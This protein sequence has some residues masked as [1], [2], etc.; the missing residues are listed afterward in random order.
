M[1][2]TQMDQ[3]HA[4]WRTGQ[5]VQI[6]PND[7]SQFARYA[8]RIDQKYD[9]LHY[10]NNPTSLLFLTEDQNAAKDALVSAVAGANLSSY[11]NIWIPGNETGTIEPSSINDVIAKLNGRTVSIEG[12]AIED[13]AE[14]LRTGHR[15]PITVYDELNGAISNLEG[16][17]RKI[18]QLPRQEKRW[19]VADPRDWS[20][21]ESLNL[22]PYIALKA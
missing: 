3:D 21:M 14:F 12:M 9:A 17:K 2:T 18:S 13:I 20:L 4:R 19:I 5:P 7:N 11:T 6:S 1:T 8:R 10:D 15:T 22:H 16:R